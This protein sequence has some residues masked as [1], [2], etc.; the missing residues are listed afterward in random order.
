MC[1]FSNKF[2][3][4]IILSNIAIFSSLFY[5][6]KVYSLNKKVNLYRD[7]YLELMAE[8]V[9]TEVYTDDKSMTM[10]TK[11]RLSNVREL[12]EL[13]IKNHVKGDVVE[14]GTWRGGAMA[15]ARSVLDAFNEANRIVYL[16]D[17][18]T[19]FPC[20]PKSKYEYE[21]TWCKNQDMN[22]NS[23]EKVK[24]S[25]IKLKLLDGVR[26][27][28]GFFRDTIKEN[29]FNRIALLRLDADSFENTMFLL[30]KLYIIVEN[31]GYII[32]DDYSYWKSCR[33]AVTIFRN[34]NNI[35]SQII[36]LPSGAVYWKKK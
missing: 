21:R 15:F 19:G 34:K 14:C 20:L 28:Q 8:V 7:K 36:T 31:N 10:I 5:H 29:L 12:I 16:F 2:I 3:I 25:F 22:S 13:I 30:E 35:S 18:F 9:S 33:D 27:Y 17:T 32:I 24:N 23:L 26:F 6:S 11:D 4:L 1:E